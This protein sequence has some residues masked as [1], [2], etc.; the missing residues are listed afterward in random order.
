MLGLSIN[1][2]SGPDPGELKEGSEP[3]AKG[4]LAWKAPLKAKQQCTVNV[5]FTVI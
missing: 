2:K 3:L 1:W 4:N 5:I